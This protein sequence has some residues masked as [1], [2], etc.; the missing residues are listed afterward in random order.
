MAQFFKTPVGLLL[1]GAFLGTLLP[2][3]SDPFHFMLQNYL[4][5]HEISK[6]AYTVWQIVDY[7]FLDSAWYL[8]LGIIAWVMHIRKVK[9]MRIVM[10]ISIIAGIAAAIGIITKF[11]IG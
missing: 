6:Q 3:G 5:T 9:T 11:I 4:Y 10:N 8:I 2:T 7:Y 1:A